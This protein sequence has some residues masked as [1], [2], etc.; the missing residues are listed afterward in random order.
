M[1]SRTGIEPVTPWLRVRCST[2]WANGPQES[3]GTPGGIRSFV[4]LRSLQRQ[5]RLRIRSVRL[6]ESKKHRSTM[7]PLYNSIVPN[8]Q[9]YFIGTP[10]GIRTPDLRI[11]SPSLYPAELQAHILIIGVRNGDRTRDIRNHNPALYQLSYSHHKTHKKHP[12]IVSSITLS[13]WMLN[14]QFVLD[15][16]CHI[17]IIFPLTELPYPRTKYI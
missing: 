7:S 1:V 15:K 3:I 17:S 4:S 12:D 2:S 16:G 11:R 8:A 5:V 10:G 13:R 6:F 9:Q 14:V